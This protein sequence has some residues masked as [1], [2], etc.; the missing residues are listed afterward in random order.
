MG[1]SG[2]WLGIAKAGKHEHQNWEPESLQNPDDCFE[3]L[4]PLFRYSSGLAGSN[5]KLV[6]KALEPNARGLLSSRCVVCR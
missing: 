2:P 5:L 4:T 3:H 6:Q 1:L